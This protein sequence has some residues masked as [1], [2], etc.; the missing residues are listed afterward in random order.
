MKTYREYI[1]WQYDKLSFW[2]KFLLNMTSPPNWGKYYLRYAIKMILKSK[3]L[4]EAKSKATIA[5]EEI[6]K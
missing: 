3:S 6:S 4:E 5:L 2:S 1:K